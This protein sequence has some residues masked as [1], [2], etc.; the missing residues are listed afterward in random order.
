LAPPRVNFAKKALR[1]G[2]QPA[3]T[4]AEP[5][6][7]SLLPPS[8]SLPEAR[9]RR[10]LLESD[11]AWLRDE[12][13]GAKSPEQRASILYQLG[14]L[15]L[16]AGRD[17]V[18]VRQLLAA[19]NSVAF[20]K[21]PLER[22]L[23]L[24]ERRRSFKNL[25]T[26]LE[27]AC[28]SAEGN[29]EIA[30]AQLASAWCALQ[31]G[32]D[33]ARA[34]ARVEAALEASPRD[35]A[36]L[37]SLEL[38]AR[39]LNDEAGTRRA[40]AARLAHST[41]PTWSALLALELAERFAADGD[42]ERANALLEE[43]SRRPTRVAFVALEQRFELGRA[44]QRSDWMLDS[45][46]ERAARVLSALEAPEL[47]QS[48]YVPLGAQSHAHALDALLLQAQLEQAAERDGAAWLT[49]ER[50]AQVDAEHPLLVRARIDLCQR[51]G[52]HELGE[53][54]LLGELGHE[55]TGAEAIVLWL[56]L[57]EARDASQRHEAALAALQRAIA[58]D[59]RCWLAR[60][61]E[62]ELLSRDGDAQGRA[63]SL[64]QIAH[65]L[66]DGGARGRHWLLAADAF[67]RQTRQLDAAR[68][69]IERAEQS[70]VPSR[71]ARRV[72]RA[73][74]HA[75]EDSRWYHAATERLLA[76]DLEDSERIGLEL[77]AW[78]HAVLTGDDAQARAH[79]ERLDVPPAGRRVARLARAYAPNDD[80]AG[81]GV[82]LASLAELEPT[83]A[84]AAALAWAMSLRAS[85]RGD[86]AAAI[87]GLAQVHAQQPGCAA[88]A[89][90]LS[91]WL[92]HAEPLRA[93]AVLR[94]TARALGDG[95]FAASLLV[96]AGL[97]SW[98]A[99]E[100]EA[101]RLDFAAAERPSRSSRAGALSAWARRASSGFG[102]EPDSA[103][104]PEERLLGA[105]ERAT[106]AAA[107]SRELN[108]LN[109][110]LR[111]APETL[112]GDLLLGARLSSLLLGRALGMRADPSELERIASTSS[113]AAQRVAAFR[114]LECMGQ[115]EP[116]PRA[117]EEC[118]RRWSESG[119]LIAALEWT[120]AAARLGQRRVECAARRRVS[121]LSTGA[122]AE[123][124]L[125]SA[126]LVAH[127]SQVDT[128]E[129]LEGRG[130]AQRLTNLETS[131]PG[132]DPRRRSRALEGAAE[133]LGADAEPI[134]GLLRGYNQLAAGD[135][136]G[137]IG[138]FRRYTDA[139]PEDPC[140]WEGVLAAARRCDDP[141]LLAEAAAK[142]GNTCRDP[143]HA[144]RL[145]EEAA[146]IFFDR[147]G[148][149]VAGQTALMRA[150][151]LDAS[152]ASSFWRLYRSLRDTAGPAER[153]ALLDRRSPFAAD[154]A[155]QVELSWER[156]RAA[157]QHGDL[158]GALAALAIVVE[159]DP[160]HLG[161]LVLFAE[162]FVSTQRYSEAVDRL[163]QLAASPEAPPQQRLASALMA[164]D[165]CEI[166]LDAPARALQV[167]GALEAEGLANVAL[168]E[169][170]ARSAAS[171]GAWSEAASLFERLMHERTRPE[172]RAEAARLALVIHR[173]RRHDPGAAGA[174][175]TVLL[176]IL[177][178]DAEALDLVLSGA[179]ERP[180]ANELLLA[181]RSELIRSMSRSPTDAEALHR[182]ARVAEQLGDAPLRQ[183][184]VGALVALGHA[185]DA[186]RAELV[187]LER[188][189]STIPP[190]PVSNDVLAELA[191][192]EDTG[193]FPEL[194]ALVAPYL[195][196]AFGPPRHVF[197]LNRK[198]RI[199]ARSGEPLRDEIAAWV[200]AF[201][202]TD[203]DLYLSPV[204]SERLVVLETDPLTVIAGASVMPPLGPFQRLSLARS[205][206]AAKRGLGP[207]IQLE[208]GDVLALIAA[209][210]SVAGVELAGP[211]HARQ[212]D[213]ERQLSSLLPRKARK[214]LQERARPVREAQ[215]RLDVWVRAVTASLD[216][217]SA[218]A[219]GD[220][221][222]IL[223]DA[224]ARELSTPAQEDRARRLLSF[225]LSPEFQVLRERF[226]VS[227]R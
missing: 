15:E 225:M 210:C 175:V 136:G 70:G 72:E 116:S 126:A 211:P 102:A 226:G 79:L 17:S 42:H 214:G 127:L 84:R 164:A 167:L 32:R 153:L 64:V 176:G 48:A 182:L 161:A 157:R 218:V 61:R 105:L 198:E 91:A 34:R 19:V 26:L 76:G 217:V 45:L 120:A 41:E 149:E 82:A 132:C 119:G 25:P 146:E 2:L 78:R 150:V 14:L 207:L 151:Q 3:T 163:A 156:A 93:A 63:N 81:S 222:V 180:L 71:L 87:E 115:T 12:L 169:R 5:M 145:F 172:E 158:D 123:Q 159:H 62:L 109:A 37:L 88:V 114:Y 216:R 134:V 193:P 196:E 101:A 128:P 173:D 60:A 51:T 16:A 56:E 143:A 30:R 137:A 118:T 94:A 85:T 75:A 110:A 184:T 154:S 95:A 44:A 55:P 54:L 90:T 111:A 223:A 197:A 113:G 103:S 135:V 39:R 139:F 155:E 69:A 224:P 199:S 21:E 187:S 98:W 201:G 68:D 160:R 47:E 10:A 107:G 191:D 144:A 213:F 192:P 96:E 18:A 9:V 148:D 53:R 6:H 147:L 181:A 133:L 13:S 152:R 194:L 170:Q 174:A 195:A 59:P 112:G 67:A 209:L 189:I 185:E 35:A 131:P 77:E 31:H 73:L 24:I 22:L 52:Q 58:L 29:E 92:H 49:L 36:A 86:R 190:L 124:A 100:R 43:A 8:S 27:H 7:I 221:S 186:S 142:L 20:F 178:T 171:A 177:P 38:L 162:I 166:Q 46:A 121:E 202:L 97:A 83:P 28:R 179:L 140:G 108:E 23:V 203:F 66:A 183:A 122:L 104:D 117:L 130:P 141:A 65:S 212:R 205:L 1:T 188:R 129:F 99:G 220:A 215:A 200:H 125:A 89:G 219:V 50:A 227:V 80:A 206:Y 165:L 168:R 74:A 208:Q 40:L 4:V 33:E 57:S 204:P 106:R 11:L 138:S